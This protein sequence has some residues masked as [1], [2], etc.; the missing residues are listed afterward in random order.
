[1]VEKVGKGQTGQVENVLKVLNNKVD[2]KKSNDIIN[3]YC[4]HRKTAF[5][6]KLEL[7]TA[8]S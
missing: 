3:Y 5:L 4:V 8:R 7:G 2:S 6:L 1:M